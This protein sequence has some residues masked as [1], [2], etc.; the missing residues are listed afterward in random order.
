M[1]PM[2]KGGPTTVA[3]GTSGVSAKAAIHKALW[4]TELATASAEG[5]HF[6]ID[7]AWS[8]SKVTVCSAEEASPCE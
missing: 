2:V 1:S 8:V 7:A 5:R 3:C 6:E 4:S